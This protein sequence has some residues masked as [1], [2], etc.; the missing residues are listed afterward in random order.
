LKGAGVHA[1]VFPARG[2]PVLQ[3]EYSPSIS[4]AYLG[5]T[6]LAGSGTGFADGPSAVAQFNNPR[7]IAVAGDG[8]IYVADADNHRIRR[9]APDGTVSTVA[10]SGTQG[11]ADGPAA[12]AQFNFPLG[13]AV[14][15]AGVVSIADSFV[16][17]VRTIAPAAP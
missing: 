3:H 2:V 11:S 13:V 10:G 1:Y 16:S 17:R 15:A 6:V 5:Q 8:G 14:N 9:I 7:G 12:A 4:S